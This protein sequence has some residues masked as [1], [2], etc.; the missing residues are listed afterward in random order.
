M[1]L[2]YDN[3]VPNETL[4]KLTELGVTTID[5]SSSEIHGAFWRFLA[6]DLHDSEFVIFRDTDSRISNREKYAVLEWIESGKTLHIMRD[7]PYHYCPF[8]SVPLSILA[9]MWG[10]KG[11][12]VNMLDEIKNF[13]LSTDKT[14]GNDQTFLNLIHNKFIDDKCTH[15][16]FFEKIPFPIKRIPGDFVGGRIDENDKPIGDDY[17][18]VL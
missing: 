15:D 14:Y 2:Y 11:N 4:I 18:L 10:I 17:K 3:T 9:G 1:V 8:G 6:A 7:H 5:M 12:K 13:N 16:E